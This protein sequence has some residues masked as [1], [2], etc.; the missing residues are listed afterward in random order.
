MHKKGQ[1]SPDARGCKHPWNKSES[2]C[3][4]LILIFYF[5]VQH[6]G[7]KTQNRSTPILQETELYD[8]A[9]PPPSP[10]PPEEQFNVDL[11]QISRLNLNSVIAVMGLNITE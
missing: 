5:Q 10:Q 7:V 11:E 9:Q 6:A 2:L 3:F 8:N 4:D 1:Q